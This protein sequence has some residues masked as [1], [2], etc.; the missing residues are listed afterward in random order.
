M[1]QTDDTEPIDQLLME[2]AWRHSLIAGLVKENDP[3]RRAEYR[4]FLLSRPW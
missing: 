1:S 2:A 4:K 3:D